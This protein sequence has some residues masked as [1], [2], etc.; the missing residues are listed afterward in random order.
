M[1]QVR[2]DSQ[3]PE[4][5]A[6]AEPGWF[7]PRADK[8]DSARSARRVG[9]SGIAF[10]G[11]AGSRSAVGAF[12]IAAVRILEPRS[13]VPSSLPATA[14]QAAPT[15]AQTALVRAALEAGYKERQRAQLLAGF[16]RPRTSGVASRGALGASLG[17]DAAPVACQQSRNG[18][19]L[20]P[21]N[22]DGTFAPYPDPR[23]EAKVKG[24]LARSRSARRGPDGRFLP[25]QRVYAARTRV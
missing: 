7:A 18:W 4:A 25:S 19:E 23:Y 21:R 6:R 11:A 2:V 22:G 12:I 20:Q 10:L 13:G 1:G 8:K 5:R 9:A 16:A 3:G 17:A 24:G 15:D 14:I